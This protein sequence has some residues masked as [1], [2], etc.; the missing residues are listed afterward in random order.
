MDWKEN[1][2]DKIIKV[3]EMEMAW[4]WDLE[5]HLAPV[6]PEDS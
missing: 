6:S 2:Q 5:I 3:Q 4:S 1:I